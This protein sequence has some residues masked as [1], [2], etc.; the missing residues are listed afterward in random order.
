VC[1]VCA[2][3]TSCALCALC[4]CFVCVV[5]VLCVL[6]VCVHTR[7]RARV[8][9]LRVYPLPWSFVCSSHLVFMTALLAHRPSAWKPVD[10]IPFRSVWTSVCNDFVSGMLHCEPLFLFACY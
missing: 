3:C 6:C 5:C 2:L 8:C 1:F 9:L 10:Y 7:A 4:V